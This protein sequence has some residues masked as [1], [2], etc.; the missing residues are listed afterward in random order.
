MTAKSKV[1]IIGPGKLTDWKIKVFSESLNSE[2][3]R[4]DENLLTGCIT[5]YNVELTNVVIEAFNQVC[6]D[7]VNLINTEGNIDAILISNSVSDGLDIDFS[8]IY[9]NN[10]TIKNSL[11][12]CLDLSG[13]RYFIESIVLME[14][15]DKGV[16]IGETSEVQIDN[17]LISNTNIGLAIKDSSSLNINQANIDFSNFCFALYRKKQEFGPSYLSLGKVNCDLDNDIYIQKGSVVNL[18]N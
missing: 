3:V 14:C 5:F 16:S 4:N 6:E 9:V 2:I 17:L 1:K 7:A 13:G 15:D 12:D 18:D 11:N 8:N 10:I